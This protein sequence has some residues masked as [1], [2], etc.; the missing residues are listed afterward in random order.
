MS[1]FCFRAVGQGLFYTGS[2]YNGAYNFVYDCGCDRNQDCLDAAIEEYVKE[3]SSKDEEAVIDFV[4]ISHLHWDHFSGL[5]KLKEKAR[6]KKIYLPYIDGTP[7]IIE[8][9]LFHEIFIR[10]GEA[11]ED[12]EAARDVYK[13]MSTL[14]GGI[15]DGKIKALNKSI[16]L[17][18]K[19]FGSEPTEIEFIKEDKKTIW[20][21]QKSGDLK[22]EIWL[23]EIF[24]NTPKAADVKKLNEECRALLEAQMADN[25]EELVSNNGAAAL[26]ALADMYKNIFKGGNKINETSLVLL[27]YPSETGTTLYQ[28]SRANRKTLLT[29]D[30]L[31]K[32]DLSEKLRGTK[33]A[34][35][36]VPHHGSLRNW[37]STNRSNISAQTYVLNFGLGNK[38]KHP[39]YATVE[40]IIEKGGK[41]YCVT[42]VQKYMY[43]IKDGSYFGRKKIALTEQRNWRGTSHK[44]NILTIA[45]VM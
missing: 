20:K 12:I 14:Y 32:G 45:D 41:I 35:L 3:I 23:F 9:I 26:K 38:Y 7:E 43:K 6:I 27:H 4:M 29:G 28:K 1:E 37:Q 16:N 8:V 25:I 30:A 40:G 34:V 33:V 44:S 18:E 42:Q 21:G 11:V 5:Y 2:L 17:S 31:I 36:Q 13:L 19:E 10:G 15:Y 39:S 24:C 22:R